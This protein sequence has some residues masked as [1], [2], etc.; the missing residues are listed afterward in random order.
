MQV[1]KDTHCPPHCEETAHPQKDA[2]RAGL[3]FARGMFGHRQ[4]KV[5]PSFLLLPS[6]LL[7]RRFGEVTSS[8]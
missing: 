3:A 1:L 2:R 6:Q 8:S 5:S 4:L 7:V